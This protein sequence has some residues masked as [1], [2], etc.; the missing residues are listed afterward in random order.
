MSNPFDLP[1]K[2]VTPEP[3]YHSRRKWLKLAGIG[4]LGI[5]AGVGGA[6]WW[7]LRGGTDKQVEER[8]RV[9]AR[10]LEKLYPAK[11]N[12]KYSKLDRPMTERLKAAR[13]CNFY[14]MSNYKNVWRYVD[15]FEPFPWKIRVDGLVHKPKTFDIEELLKLIPLEERRYRHRCVE[16]W[17]MAVP[18]TGFPITSLLKLV[19]PMAKA[20][21]VRF[22]SF[23]RPEQAPNMRGNDYPWPYTEGLTIKEAEN[24]LAFIAT[25]IYGRPLLKQHGAPIRLVVPWKY[26]FKSGKSIVR[27]ELTETR[28]ATFWNTVT[29]HEYGFFANVNPDVSHPRW[30]QKTERMLGT[31]EERPTLLYNGYADQVAHLYKT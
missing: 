15:D 20:K 27:I 18:W 2:D 23:N 8:G 12:P 14:E 29:P 16:A 17:A 25:G 19:E 6:F 1:E 22:V 13:Y 24:E 4:A 3:V 31:D 7:H 26:G 10:S 30:S 5:G 28:P 11:L 9:D 21:F